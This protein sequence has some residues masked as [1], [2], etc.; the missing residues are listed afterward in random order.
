MNK[1]QLQDR[2][3]GNAPQLVAVSADEAL[4]V[5][6]GSFFSKLKAAA[7]WVY[8]HVIAPRINKLPGTL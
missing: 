8:D 7:V 6:G 3:L 2:S 4:L 5:D 1:Q